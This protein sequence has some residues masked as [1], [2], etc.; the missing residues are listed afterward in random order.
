MLALSVSGAFLEAIGIGAVIPLF[1][2]LSGDGNS[3]GYFIDLFNGF[4]P[5]QLMITLL[6]L[7]F[8][9]G[10]V[11]LSI[12]IILSKM[13]GELQIILRTQILNKYSR[14]SYADYLKK[15]IGD[16]N[17][18]IN[19]HASRSL[20]AFEHFI[21][22]STQGVSAVVFLTFA[23]SISP[24]LA[25]L[26]CL[27]S[28]LLYSL[29]G[30]Q[31]KR[32]QRLSEYFASKNSELS[33][34]FVQF[35]LGFKYLKST[36]LIEWS[37]SKLDLII[38]NLAK[39]QVSLGI[40]QGIVAAL[41]EPIG[42]SF[43]LFALWFQTEYRDHGL[44]ETLVILILFYRGFSA[45]S[46]SQTYKVKMSEYYGSL[47]AIISETYDPNPDEIQKPRTSTVSIKNIEKI[48]LI[49]V[50][51]KFDNNSKNVLSDV[52]LVIN[53]RELIGII[54]QSGSGKTTLIDIISGLL[55]PTFGLVKINDIELT[56][57]TEGSWQKHI[58]YV[59]SQ[60]PI[61][62]GS[63][64]FN[65][66]LGL[67]ASDNELNEII[68][69][70]S[71]SDFLRELDKGL[72]TNLSNFGNS[73]SD[74]QKQRLLIAR[75]IFKKPELLIFDEATNALDPETQKSISTLLQALKGNL[76]ILIIAH[77][78][79][80]IEFSDRI[81][82]I[83]SGKIVDTGRYQYLLNKKDSVLKNFMKLESAG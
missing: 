35:I 1:A 60:S 28:L 77:Q 22:T 27:F 37:K 72:D 68:K 58:G 25:I 66:T 12:H 67:P 2:A 80:N 45:F 3:N 73:L 52:N 18:N 57:I 82:V 59:G 64:R 31:N 16:M 5:R 75:E 69:K 21:R 23:F 62:N 48:E 6:C 43:I 50:S 19:E 11:I 53:K 36:N 30:F 74:G 13:K 49:D 15:V 70:V 7:F 78:M 20:L 42:V 8:A 54:G 9:K 55:E 81:V 4:G 32:S 56:D 51:Y 24:E 40:S 46:A 47:N 76:T 83:D 63:V 41:R 39:T 29:F 38:R 17:A 61:F 34:E 26:A 44:S 33:G 79:R 14:I 71:L 10:F 65:I